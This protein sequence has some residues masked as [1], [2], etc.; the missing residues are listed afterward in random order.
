MSQPELSIV[1][2]CYRREVQLHRALW[3]IARQ[4]ESE[5]AEV[6][7]IDNNDERDAVLRLVR[8]WS[9][10]GLTFQYVHRP[11]PGGAW[12]NPCL[13]WNL[14]LQL[15]RAPKL[16]LTGP[17]IIH[18]GNT[19][20]SLTDPLDQGVDRA[21]LASVYDLSQE[22][23]DGMEERNWQQWIELSFTELKEICA[24]D[25]SEWWKVRCHPFLRRAGLFFLGSVLTE[26]ARA[27][28]GFDEDY[29]Y[30]IGFDDDDFIRRLRLRGV[31]EVY[32]E[33]G[34]AH[35]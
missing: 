26:T 30:G 32:D 20:K 16:I 5:Q 7:L 18:I 23:S 19:L 22:V 27:V 21:V 17:D 14:G 29:Q 11:N 33:I 3:T 10:N 4:P 9:D 8:Q 15:A 2:G 28:G 35:V 6:V 12:V 24:L 1:M 31:E 13:A 34:R 25:L